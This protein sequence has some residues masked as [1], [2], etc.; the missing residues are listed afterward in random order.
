MPNIQSYNYNNISPNPPPKD[1]GLILEAHSSPNMKVERPKITVND[2]QMNLQS[3]NPYSDKEANQ[4][5]KAISEDIYTGTK[6]EKSNH[7][8]NF[9]RY[10]TIFGILALITA[11]LGYFR[12]G[13]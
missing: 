10:F 11:A 9:K 13:K 8:F 4:K 2:L 1:S 3:K 12:K 5:L 7:E 6:K